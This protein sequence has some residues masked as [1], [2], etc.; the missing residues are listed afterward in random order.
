MGNHGQNMSPSTLLY[1]MVD[2]Y[3]F[4][5]LLTQFE[6]VLKVQQHEEE[7]ISDGGKWFKSRSR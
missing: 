3:T 7:R 1:D 2:R 5:C 6:S 4:E